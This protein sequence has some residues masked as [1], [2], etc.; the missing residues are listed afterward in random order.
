MSDV[1]SESRKAYERE[2]S[3]IDKATLDAMTAWLREDDGRTECFYEMLCAERQ[4]SVSK[5][6]NRWFY[7]AVGK[8]EAM[9]EALAKLSPFDW[10][11]WDRYL[12]AATHHDHELHKRIPLQRFERVACAE[13]P[14]EFL[15]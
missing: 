3:S 9:H 5:A 11:D 4:I 15:G 2:V 7:R 1:L 6:A 8:R 12:W 10:Y 14:A 13:H